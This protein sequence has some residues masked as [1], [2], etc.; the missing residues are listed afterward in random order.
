MAAV[1]GVDNRIDR[2]GKFADVIANLVLDSGLLQCSRAP[3][4]AM[5]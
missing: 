4:R 2:S 3:S 5:F 1:F